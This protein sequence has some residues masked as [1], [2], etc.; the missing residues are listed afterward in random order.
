MGAV[1]CCRRREAE[2]A[3]DAL[4]V[5]VEQAQAE[6]HALTAALEAERSAAAADAASLRH[7]LEQV[8]PSAYAFLWPISSDTQGVSLQTAGVT[9]SAVILLA[10]RHM[11][12][13]ARETVMFV[14]VRG[15][16]FSVT[17]IVVQGY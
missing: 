12:M 14:S 6:V 1:S 5:L 11:G 4:Q 13:I 16:T 15:R 7:S 10:A 17:C 9:L 3:R 8:P 2:A